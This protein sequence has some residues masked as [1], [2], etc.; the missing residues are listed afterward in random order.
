QPP[1]ARRARVLPGPAL[2]AAVMGG[3]ALA[4]AALPLWTYSTSL[5]LLGT[6]HVATE[7]RFVEA[8]FAARLGPRLFWGMATLLLAVAT[9]R[10]LK[11]LDLWGGT[12]AV[13]L[14][15]GLVA[16]LGAL[17]LPALARAGRAPL[18]AG[19]ATVAALGVGVAAWPA[20]TLLLL[21]VL[22]NWTPVGFLAEGLPAGERP[23]GR[24]L[25]LLAFALLPLLLA[26][27][28]PGQLLA[29]VGASWPE[30]RSL[31]TG[32]LA[33]HLGVYL[34]E[35]WH[36]G[37]W[38]QPLF[39]AV[40]F[41]QCMHYATVIGV[42]PRLAPGGPSAPAVLGLSRLPRALFVGGVLA[43][44]LVGL[45]GYAQDF[46]DTRRWYGIIAALHAW[47]EIPVL[48][49]ALLPLLDRRRP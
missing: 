17:V 19:L 24:V 10:L 6:A 48:M 4:A 25:G 26:S 14:E 15:L 42:L 44:T 49:L 18:A 29:A 47:V 40:V 21:A 16:G 28:L 7:L 5:A 13:R 43:L 32:P 3:S 37:P 34:P 46:A 45:W 12:P 1:P 33:R 41:A 9:L 36:A 8:R 38:A 30:L 39:S 31:P 22:H 35:T 2:A 20:A 27:G 23:S 11:L